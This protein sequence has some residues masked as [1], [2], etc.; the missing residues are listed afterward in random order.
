MWD[1]PGPGIK[2]VSS[3][4]QA[5]SLPLTHQG[6]PGAF[7]ISKFYLKKIYKATSVEKIFIK[8]NVPKILIEKF[9]K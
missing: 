2:P 9:K 8:D 4:W 6:S 1:L 5:D 7:I 3:K